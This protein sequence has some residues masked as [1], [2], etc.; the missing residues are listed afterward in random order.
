M[1]TITAS[2]R[3]DH[4]AINKIYNELHNGLDSMALD[5]A[6]KSYD[7]S[8]VISGALRMST[9]IVERGEHITR[10][11]VGGKGAVGDVTGEYHFVDYAYKK[12]VS[13][14]T[15]TDRYLTVAADNIFQ[16]RWQSYFKGRIK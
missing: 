9:D 7:L 14:A 2:V 15:G 16:A 8:P 3:I 12:W 11:T 6:S 5:I 1:S 10:V 4:A 13:N